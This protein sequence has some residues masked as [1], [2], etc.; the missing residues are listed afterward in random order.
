[1]KKSDIHF[2]ITEEDKEFIKNK[3]T[4]LGYKTVSAFLVASAK[5]HFKVQ[6]DMT[7]YQKINTEINYIGRNINQVAR[8]INTDGY[9]TDVDLEQIKNYQK[10]IIA[11]QK[12]EYKR[13]QEIGLKMT[14]ETMKKSEKKRLI[15]SFLEAQLPIPKRVLLSDL[16]ENFKDDCLYIYQEILRSKETENEFADYLLETLYQGKIEKLSDEDFIKL[17]DNVFQ[18]TEKLKRKLI[19]LNLL[20]VDNDWYEIRDIFRAY[21]LI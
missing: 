1:M 19:N 18:F 14:S 9:Y 2:R 15:E 17:S 7:S 3:A 8:K 10:Q 11:L 13:L 12:K 5:S 21:E 20:F 4:E 16:Y 6:V